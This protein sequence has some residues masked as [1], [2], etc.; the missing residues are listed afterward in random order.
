MFDRR[1]PPVP[2][3]LALAFLAAAPLGCQEATTP[4]PRSTTTA[5]ADSSSAIV[6]LYAAAQSAYG[7]PAEVV[8]RDAAAW[9]AAWNAAWPNS[10]GGTPA[11]PAVDFARD[12]VILVA[13]G[14]RPTGG[15]SV[16]VDAVE[17]V[18]T[19]AVVRYTVT[20]PGAGCMTT[21]AITSPIAVVRVPRVDGAVRFEG[22]RV[23]APC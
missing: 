1:I 23:A 18:G 22:R 4:A 19:G 9:R 7:E 14:S 8:A 11:A 5:V 6:R 13:T 21:Q 15:Y 12:M 3:L 16:R 2:S 20:A 10:A 17:P